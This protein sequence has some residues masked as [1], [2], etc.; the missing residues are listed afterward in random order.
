MQTYVRLAMMGFS[1]MVTTVWLQHVTLHLL[2]QEDWLLTAVA[3]QQRKRAVAS[4]ASLD[5]ETQTV[6]LVQKLA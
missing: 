1:R 4:L 5:T 3:K 6:A 2:K